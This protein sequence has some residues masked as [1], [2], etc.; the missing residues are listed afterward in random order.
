LEHGLTAAGIPADVALQVASLPPTGA[1]FAAFLGY[2]PMGTLLPPST[3]AALPE[4]TRTLVLSKEF[5]PGLLSGPFASGITIAFGV[6]ALCCAGAAI[7]SLLRGK[8]VIQGEQVAPE[9]APVGGTG[10]EPLGARSGD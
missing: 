10:T 2:N 6:S 8:P 7:V 3:L 4:A 1:L 5:F 9:P